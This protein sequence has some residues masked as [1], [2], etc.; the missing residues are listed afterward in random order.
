VSART[1]ERGE[2][3]LN[4]LSTGTYE[5][6]ATA[7]QGYNAVAR[8]IDIHDPR[9][10]GTTVLYLRHDARVSGRV[11]DS[12][13]IGVGGL[14]LALLSSG[15]PTPR[16]SAAAVRAWTRTDG[17]FE[18]EL[19]Q[20][21]TYELG[22]TAPRPLNG[23][24]TEVSAFY[25]GVPSR[26][27]AT[28]VV[29]AVGARVRLADFVVPATVALATVAGAVV[30]EA[31]NPVRRARVVLQQNVEGGGT[32]GPTFVTGEDGRFAFSLVEGA[33][34][35]VHVTRYIGDERRPT[36]TQISMVPVTVASA[37]PA[38]SV[39]MKPNRD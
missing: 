21:G 15:Q 23:R 3:Q 33:R 12:R 24:P 18:L 1:N 2:F 32:V 39:I 7:P 28:K 17:T 16:A 34:Y 13:G 5:L 25:P 22:F 6:K 27:D 29:V 30:D 38:L 4:G 37:T 19:V 36:G 9:G 8:T 35:V 11:V 31:G 20:P 10:C 14:P 26:V